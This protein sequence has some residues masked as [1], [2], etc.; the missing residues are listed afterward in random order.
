MI[1][2]SREKR[3]FRRV[4]Q[5]GGSE[6]L[7]ADFRTHIYPRHFHDRYVFGV[8]TRGG[9]A[10][11]YRGCQ[12]IAAA[13]E[14][15]V[16]NPGEVHD[17]MGADAEGWAYRMSYLPPEAVLLG[18]EGCGELPFFREP[19]IRDSW[20]ADRYSRLHSTVTDSLADRLTRDS[21]FLNT[22]AELV[23]RHG[24]RGQPHHKGRREGRAVAWVREYLHTHYAEDV[25]LDDLAALAG[26]TPLYLIKVFRKTVG[27]PPHAYLIQRRI[28][29]AMQ[30]LREGLPIAAVA[31][32]CGFADQSHLTRNF[33]KMIGVTP[34][35][36][37]AGSFKKTL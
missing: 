36:F 14:I 35:E 24:D 9:E 4:E 5:G 1:D 7:D 11:Y 8:V 3:N 27:L 26:L 21:F 28:L 15:V 22:L 23:I 34:G 33:K 30:G 2:E 37:R 31:A 12:H 18:Q 19:V 32:E 10:F 17:G 6:F 25:T 13:G 29:A 16:L 20:L